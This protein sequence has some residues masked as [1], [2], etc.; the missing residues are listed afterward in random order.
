MNKSAWKRAGVS[1]AAVAVIAGVAG[2]QDGD[3]KAAAGPGK[4]EVQG[5]D[6][7][8]KVVQAAYQKTAEAKSA[9]V[10]MHMS[11]AVPQGQDGSG[12]GSTEVTGIQSWNP[13]AADFTVKSS[14]FSE[15]GL[16]TAE[17][18]RVIMLDGVLYAD[19]GTEKAAQMDGK[20]WMKLDLKAAA[21]ATGDSAAQKQLAGGLENLNQDP[22]KQLA[23]LAASPNV[24]DLGAAKVNGIEA[25]HYKGSL[26]V[27]EVLASNKALQS[28]L[29]AEERQKLL[30]NVKKAGIE[31]YDIEAWV[32]PDNYPVRMIVKTESP[33][34]LTTITTNYTDYGAKATVQ[35]PA[36]KDTFDLF[37]ML[38]G[39]K[40]AGA[41]G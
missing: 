31:G 10:T 17:Q 11:V 18:S 28:T 34:A 13:S 14:A 2:C 22:T 32:S 20:R 35:A 25:R 26:T 6:Q 38:K 40:G 27:D 16:G 15:N 9:K 29:S 37:E 12:S 5:G 19:M 39:L 3:G 24:K 21:E 33:Q 7:I 8:G 4:Q 1:L 36:A 30:A 23:L 41:Q